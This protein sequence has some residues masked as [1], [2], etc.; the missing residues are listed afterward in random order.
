M[1]NGI[2]IQKIFF[3]P[4]LNLD[5]AIA[6]IVAH[7]LGARHHAGRH[8]GADRR[9]VQRLERAGARSA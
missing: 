9:Q 8:P 6:Q 2:S 1:L 4:E 5:L 3:Q 7:E